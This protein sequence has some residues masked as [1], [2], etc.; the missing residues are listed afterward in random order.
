MQWLI[1]QA[2]W[3]DLFNITS[4]SPFQ[5]EL[6]QYHK[7]LLSLMQYGT[8]RQIIVLLLK[9]ASLLILIISLHELLKW[10]WKCINIQN[11]KYFSFLGINCHSAN[12]SCYFNNF[13]MKD[14]CWCCGSMVLTI[15]F[16]KYFYF[17]F[18]NAI[19]KQ[20]CLLFC[21]YFEKHLKI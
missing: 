21:K 20:F 5:N 17:I 1:T 2:Y 14:M 10:F 3:T 6:F 19:Y 13:I 18:F 7:F 8:S 11:Q 9:H 15:E 12:V 4:P 16:L